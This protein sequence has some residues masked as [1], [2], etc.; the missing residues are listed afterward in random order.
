MEGGAKRGT[1]RQ[2]EERGGDTEAEG[3][4]ETGMEP[5]EPTPAHRWLERLLGEW[6][7]MGEG[8]P[9]A[10]IPTQE[11]VGTETVRTLGGIWYRLEGTHEMPNGET[12]VSVMTLGYDTR[13]KRYV[14][15][16]I[17]TMM[18]HQWVY[19]GD[20]DDDGRVLTLNTEGPAMSGEGQTARYRDVIELRSDDHRVLSSHIRGDDGEWKQFMEV[21]YRRKG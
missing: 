13:R 4:A 6:E 14:G 7:M 3:G 18:T 17:G 5:A 20:L 8:D 21:H 10:D 16:W 15:S 2:N 11:I 19:E 9:G 12:G 1:E